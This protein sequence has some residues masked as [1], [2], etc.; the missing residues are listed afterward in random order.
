MTTKIAPIAIA[1]FC[2]FVTCLQTCRNS[3]NVE[4]SSQAQ[5]GDRNTGRTWVR[6]VSHFKVADLLCVVSPTMASQLSGDVEGS[7]LLEDLC[8]HP[9]K[10][11]Q[12]SSSLQESLRVAIKSHFD[13]AK[14]A[15]KAGGHNFGPLPELYVDGFD[16]EQIWEELKLHSDPFLKYAESTS[17]QLA[18]LSNQKLALLPQ[19]ETKPQ[20]EQDASSDDESSD[21]DD[22]DVADATTGGRSNDPRSNSNSDGGSDSEDSDGESES[23]S[24][25]DDAAPLG[26]NL[27]E[28]E[29]DTDAAA[30]HAQPSSKAN[31]S[32]SR[33]ELAFLEQMEAFA[34]QEER[35][36]YGDDAEAGA[37]D[38]DDDDW[39]DALFAAGSETE[40]LQAD[41]LKYGDVFS[42]K[43]SATTATSK[44]AHTLVSDDDADEDS[45][46]ESDAH[47]DDESDAEFDDT[48]GQGGAV[49]RDDSNVGAVGAENAQEEEKDPAK[50]SAFE[51]AQQR[52]KRQIA[53]LEEDAIAEKA[54]NLVG[55]ARAGDRPENSL[56]GLHVDYETVR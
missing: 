4:R 3:S 42:D 8:R 11:I 12:P 31:E 2:V 51:K 49:Q 5:S 23:D 50:M 37:G 36:E 56:L 47:S 52:L 45:D 53:A 15:E 33:D 6:R 39:Q 22:S 21:V 44:N 32:Q 1:F 13:F 55:E 9:E 28:S 43:S 48:S 26:P 40:N 17:K 35:K 29:V 18:A 19:A 24:D 7:K 14:S 54:W 25:S 20:K 34:E 30:A 41:K 10:F 16:A 27:P 46:A 38:S